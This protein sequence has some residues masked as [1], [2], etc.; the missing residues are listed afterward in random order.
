VIAAQPGDDAPVRPLLAQPRGGPTVVR[1]LLGA[2]L[3]RLR[4]AAGVSREDAGKVI[5]GSESKLSRLELG[6]VGFKERDVADLLTRYGVLDPDERA[7][8]VAMVRDA[9]SPGWWQQYGDVLTDWFEPYIGLEEAACR[10]RT[11]EVQFVPGLLQTEDYARAL[12]RLGYPNA[13]A[14]DIE[15]RVHLRMARQKVLTRDDPPMVWAVVDE[16]ALR[17]PLGG[18]AVMRAQLERLVELTTQPKVTLYVVPFRVGGHA[19]VGGPFSILRFDAPELTDV[20][21]VEHLTSALYLDKPADVEG[22][23]VVMERLCVEAETRSRSR[24]T[25]LN[26]IAKL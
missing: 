3:R 10:I 16:A 13:P 21:Y 4:E 5:R 25:L 20:V 26:L 7:A 18:P 15:R 17:R 11:Y 2:Q 22:Y 14:D 9:N 1:L 8:M 12:I 23:S 19:A 24:E 6:R